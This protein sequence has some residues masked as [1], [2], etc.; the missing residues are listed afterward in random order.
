MDKEEIINKLKEGEVV[1]I[2]KLQKEFNLGY[3]K[4]LELFNELKSDNKL[5]Q[6][7]NKT[8][9]YYL[10]EPQNQGL[11]L[12]F[13]DIDGVLNSS[14][15]KEKCGPYRGIEDSKVSFLKELVDKTN[16]KIVLI[17]SWKEWWFKKEEH[18]NRQDDLA[19]YLDECLNKFGLFVW[20]KINDDFAL[21]RGDAIV[22]FINFLKQ[23]G[24][25]VNNYVIFD[26]EIFDYKESK[27]TKHLIQTSFENGGLSLKNIKQATAIL[28]RGALC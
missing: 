7:K 22:Q 27:Q 13:L 26:D 8:T 9:Y 20:N 4:A 11:N 17:S 19:N 5:V 1:T 23:E 3:V 14:S 6:G 15:T 18:K 21:G 28:E 24:I 2:S 16:A 12:I 25:K 10:Y